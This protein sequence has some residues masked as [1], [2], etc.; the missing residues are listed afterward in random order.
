V[1]GEVD[2][3]SSSAEINV[4]QIKFKFELERLDD[5]VNASSSLSLLPMIFRLEMDVPISNR[6]ET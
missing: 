1:I 6:L 2:V 4:A 3:V 5:V